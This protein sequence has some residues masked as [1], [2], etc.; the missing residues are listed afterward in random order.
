MA[1]V[2]EK[3]YKSGDLHTISLPE[4]IKELSDRIN[5]SYKSISKDIKLKIDI[6]PSRIQTDTAVSM[7]LIINE[8]LS[9][10]Y[11]YAFIHRPNGEISIC[12]KTIQSGEKEL[13]IIDNGVG[14]PAD[15]NITETSTLGLKLVNLTVIDQLK[16]T[17][18][19]KS[20]NGTGFYIRLNIKD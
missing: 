12:Y 11:K 1:L 13:I 18:E 19:I 8:L 14:L 4:Y 9:N 3:L 2:Q 10:A 20:E 15:F 17:L 16:G 6:E 5:E 7:G